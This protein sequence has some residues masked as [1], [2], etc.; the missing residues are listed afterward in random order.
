MGYFVGRGLADITGEAADCGMLGYGK[1][2]QQTSG[3]HTRLR[4]RA[5]VMVDEDSGGTSLG[6]A[7]DRLQHALKD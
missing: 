7:V 6:A 2:S 1:L 3:L 5:F 4:S